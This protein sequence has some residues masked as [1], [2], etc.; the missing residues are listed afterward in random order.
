[1]ILRHYQTIGVEFLAARTKAALGD[2]MGLGKSPQ[3][4]IAAERARGPLGLVVI[5]AP[6]ATLPGLAS[7]VR[8]WLGAVPVQ[9]LTRNGA[10]PATAGYILLGWTS[11]A[12]RLEAL[13]AGPRLSVLVLDE[14]HKV[15]NPDTKV[16]RAVFGRY[17]RNALGEWART[18]A[19]CRHAARLWAV[20][21]TPIPNRPIE[22]Q[23]LLHLGF[24]LPWAARD[25]Y[26]QAYCL[27]KNKFNRQGFDYLGARNLEELNQKILASGV[28][29][30]RTAADVPGELPAVEQQIVPLAVPDYAA[31]GLDQGK[32]L[33]ILGRGETVPFEML[34]AYRAEMGRRKAPEVAAWVNAWLDASGLPM[35]VFCWHKET[36][37]L[38]ADHL[39]AAGVE[40]ICADGDVNASERQARVDRFAAGEGRVFLGTIGACGTGLNGLHRRA[41]AA[42]FAEFS[43][44]PAEMAQAVGRVRRIGGLG[45]RVLAYY[46]ASADS[47]EAHILSTVVRKID[48]ATKIL[49]GSNVAPAV[50]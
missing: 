37:A 9:I 22:I 25:T 10:P 29:L 24:G 32:I 16:C 31:P 35:V 48:H 34:S 18:P 11:A 20:S 38:V 15:K 42:A 17:K 13:L 19:L 4:L 23:P 30:R 28:L 50:I 44:V 36:L 2:E 26:G 41:S 21:G 46:L 40:C 5:L 47:L 8:Q 7:M 14:C 49:A 12:T 43:F 33:A 3:Y 45:S 39:T 1:M 27:R 6:E